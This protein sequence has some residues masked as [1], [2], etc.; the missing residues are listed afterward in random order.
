MSYNIE[1]RLTSNKGKTFIVDAED[2]ELVSQYSWTVSPEG[3]VK[4]YIEKSRLDPTYTGKRE[5]RVIYLHRLVI[6]AQEDQIIDHI[7]QD[8]SDNRKCNLRVATK[9]LNGLNSSSSKG[10][11][12]YRGVTENKGRGKQYVANIQ[13]NGKRKRLGSFDTPEEA[14]KT[15]LK[16]QKGIIYGLSNRD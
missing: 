1:I 15:Y 9:S 6:G 3:Y 8:K 4:S 2:L 14:S 10:K 7:S 13:V 16:A 12:P 5:R 11:I